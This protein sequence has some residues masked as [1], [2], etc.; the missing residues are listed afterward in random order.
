[1]QRKK[2]DRRWNKVWYFFM[3]VAAGLIFSWGQVG[4]RYQ[5][6]EKIDEKEYLLLRTEKDCDM[7]L[8]PCAAFAPD[9]AMVIKLQE[10][11][12]WNTVFVKT[13]GEA[14][15]QQSRVK[16]SFEPESSLYEAEL[17]PVR[18]QAPDSWY[19]DFQFPDNHQTSWKLRVKIEKSDKL[20]YVADFPVPGLNL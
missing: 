10:N 19:S 3:L 7:Q 2:V 8:S 17:L 11:Q 15:T 9:Y 4:T 1:M 12:G 13:A 6:K 5:Q 20:V 14:L 16:M 18:F